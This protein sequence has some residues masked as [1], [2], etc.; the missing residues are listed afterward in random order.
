MNFKTGLEIGVAL[1]TT[2]LTILGIIDNNNG[3]N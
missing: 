1:G 3:G 2:I